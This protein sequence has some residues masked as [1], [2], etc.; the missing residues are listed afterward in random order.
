MDHT[1]KLIWDE[2]EDIVTVE[3]PSQGQ[4]KRDMVQFKSEQGKPVVVFHEQ[5]PF[6]DHIIVGDGFHEVVNLPPTGSFFHFLC[7][8]I[9]TDDTRVHSK[10]SGGDF[11]RPGERSS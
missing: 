8:V 4:T 5:S 3:P 7:G 9:P 1:Y 2:H 11:P 10:G 6:E